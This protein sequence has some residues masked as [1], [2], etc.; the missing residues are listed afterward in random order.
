MKPTYV[1][2]YNYL[3]Y[4]FFKE[5][6]PLEHCIFFDKEGR[7]IGTI[8]AKVVVFGQAWKRKN[9]EELISEAVIVNSTITRVKGFTCNQIAIK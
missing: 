6:N 5:K 3:T 4:K 9:Y 2:A 8:N 1:I 7:L